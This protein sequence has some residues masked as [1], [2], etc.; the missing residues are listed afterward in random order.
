MMFNIY[1]KII[2]DCI[3][4]LH[5]LSTHTYNW[6]IIHMGFI[7]SRTA[8]ISWAWT[9]SIV[10][11]HADKWPGDDYGDISTFFSWEWDIIYNIYIYIFI[12]IIYIHLL[13]ELFIYLFIMY[14]IHLFF[15][16]M[17]LYRALEHLGNVC[18]T[19]DTMF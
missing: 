12:F 8:L 16:N 9:R 6:Y 11:R 18:I 14:Y 17:D 15:W 7:A 10:P 3:H 13:I 5:I 4:D 19:L 2:V 1:Q